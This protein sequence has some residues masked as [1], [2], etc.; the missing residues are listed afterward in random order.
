MRQSAL[1]LFLSFLAAAQTPP[2]R[3]G[4]PINL[5]PPATTGDATTVVFA[6]A[7]APDGTPL[8]ATNLYLFTL[9][10]NLPLHQLTNYTGTQTWT[11]VT[12]VTCGSTTIAYAAAPSGPGSGE[13]VHFLDRNSGADRTL[14]TDKQGCVQP[15]CIG[16][17]RPCVGPVHLA[18]GGKVLFAAARQLPFFV[19]NADGSG[20]TQLPV[21]QGAL[22][23]SPKRVIGGGAIV[24]TSA[25]SSGAPSPSPQ[26]A[27]DVWL[28]NLDGSGLKQVTKFGDA[29]VG[30][31]N[32]T[33]SADGTWIAFESNY[34]DSGS[35]EATQ[36]WLVKADGTGL[37]QLSR[38]PDAAT[39]PSISG[40]GTTVTFLQSGQVLR[41]STAPQAVPPVALTAYSTSAARDAVLSDDGSQV[42]F[43]VGP[44]YGTAAAVNRTIT[45][46]HP[47][48]NPFDLL[49]IYG[50]R[51]LNA[52]G[53][54]SAAG[55]GAPT[56]GSLFTAYGANLGADEMV[57][58]QSFPLPRSLNGLSLEV[59][60]QAVPLTAVT[61]WQINGQLPQT[62]PAG[63][64]TFQVRD[65][66][67][68]TVQP[69]S[70]PTVS[71]L[72]MNFYFPYVRG[73]L[74]YSQAAALHAGTGIV[75]DMD[76]PAMTGET[77]EVYGVGL[78]VTDPIVDAG[79]P[80]PFS[81]PARSVQ[82]PRVQIAGRDA[83]VTFAGLAPGLAGVYQVNVVVPTGIPPGVQTLSWFGAGN[84]VS[85]SSVAV[86]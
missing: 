51:F 48:P 2:F 15:L 79:L 55:S 22:A 77:L 65:P 63:M 44:A 31:A 81:P 7:V 71:Y 35:A 64:A 69:A 72:P 27:T 26:A 66:N 8:T 39:G 47:H 61:P 85:Y 30:A 62:V 21:Y 34:A 46:S 12:S 82:T 83:T 53:V 76:H 32:A 73:H 37:R 33:I 67:S 70:E 38:G 19:V 3:L 84:P 86:K 28:I 75:A 17:A 56:L 41:V 25:A 50:P 16:C 60:G 14:F 42:V 74:F 23:P 40:D 13:E 58:A 18:D 24:F 57:T 68:A 59:N 5:I 4:D 54:T 78:G 10:M 1:L 20:L 9:T 49:R 29:M 45:F 6:A 11:G 52:N 36:I 80:S 43:T